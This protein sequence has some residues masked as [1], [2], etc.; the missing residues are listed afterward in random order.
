MPAFTATVLP[1]QVFNGGDGAVALDKHNLTAFKVRIGEIV[2]FL[3][4][5]GDRH[6]GDHAVGLA[7]T[8]AGQ[9]C[10][11]PQLSIVYSKP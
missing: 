9:C 2:G 3:A 7:G 10:T 5:I 6:A 11:Q 8:Q 4:L 1:A